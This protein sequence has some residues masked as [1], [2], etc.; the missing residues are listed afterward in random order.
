MIYVL[1]GN[2]AQYA[3]FLIS[4]KFRKTEAKYIIDAQSL[5]GVKLR[6]EVDR[7]LLVGTYHYRPDYHEILNLLKQ[8]GIRFA[9]APQI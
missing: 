5:L 9:Q 4:S 7:V 6:S 2:F 8:K 1:S 3:D